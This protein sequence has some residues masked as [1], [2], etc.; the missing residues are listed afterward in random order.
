MALLSRSERRLSDRHCSHAAHFL[1]TSIRNESATITTTAQSPKMERF[2]SR[3][4]SAPTLSSDWDR[5][6]VVLLLDEVVFAEFEL[7]TSSR[8]V[9]LAGVDSD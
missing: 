8:D 1:T 9:T 6:A 4:D 3:L 2:E 5:D 7:A